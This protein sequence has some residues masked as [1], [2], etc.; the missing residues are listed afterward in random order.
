[1]STERRGAY[2]GGSFSTLPYPAHFLVQFLGPA[3]FAVYAYLCSRAD[4]QTGEVTVSNPRLA[5]E[6]GFSESRVRQLKADLRNVG[7]IDVYRQYDQRGERV[8]LIVV[9]DMR[10]SRNGR[11][12]Q[13]WLYAADPNWLEGFGHDDGEDLMPDP[14]VDDGDPTSVWREMAFGEPGPAGGVQRSFMR[15]M[16]AG[17]SMVN[18]DG[19]RRQ[20]ST[21]RDIIRVINALCR[22]DGSGETPARRRGRAIFENR[23]MRRPTKDR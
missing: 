19:T 3:R 18:S 11:A 6:T 15:V 22:P 7:L 4:N 9:V 21:P 5:A 14:R 10:R 12:S 20:P 2:F 13:Y 16:L 8:G 23:Y 1:M 17:W